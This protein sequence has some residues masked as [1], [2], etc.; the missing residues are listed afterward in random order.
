MVVF[1]V[2]VAYHTADWMPIAVESYLSQF[3]D[4]RILVVDNNPQPGETGWS[5]TCRRERRWLYSHPK[6]DVIYRR[7]H[8]IGIPAQRTHGDG[9]DL[10]LQWCRSRGADIMLHFEP[11]CLVTGRDWRLNL[12]S[13]IEQGAWMAGA[14]PEAVGANPSDPVGLA[15]S[16]STDKLCRAAT[17]SSGLAATIQRACESRDSPVGCRSGG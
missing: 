8:C 17:A 12:V 10:A 7:T 4:D 5:A 3:P 1:P 13:A 16:G 6:L 11:D 15:G 14:G 9:M 2:I